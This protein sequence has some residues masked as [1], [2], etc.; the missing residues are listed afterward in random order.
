MQAPLF[1]PRFNGIFFLVATAAGLINATILGPIFSADD[2]LASAS[3]AVIEIQLATLLN[4]VMVIAIVAIAIGFFPVL[5]KTSPSMAMGFLVARVIEAAILAI[6]GAFWWVW[7]S[8]GPETAAFAHSVS[9][10]LFGIGAQ[11]VFGLTAVILN[12]SLFQQKSYPD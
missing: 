7:F 5:A 9:V 4:T 6:A 2:L 11:I 1:R 8:D 10:V 3:S 12:T